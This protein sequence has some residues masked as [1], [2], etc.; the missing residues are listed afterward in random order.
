[1]NHPTRHLQ[2]L[3]ED[4]ALASD[5]RSKVSAIVLDENGRVI[6]TGHNRL[7]RVRL[8]NS[9][10]TASEYTVHAE[11]DCLRTLPRRS[12]SKTI[13]VFKLNRTGLWR[14]G[15]PCLSC[16]HLIQSWGIREVLY[17]DDEDE[18]HLPRWKRIRLDYE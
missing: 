9:K 11:H 14:N 10:R 15:H 6:S 3:L 13:I 5:V 8:I 4:L 18:Y 1:M 16:M 7:M 2:R 17:S 12:R